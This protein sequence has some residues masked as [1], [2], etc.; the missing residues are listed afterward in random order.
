M[1]PDKTQR[2]VDLACEKGASNWLTV[3]PFKDMDFDLNSGNF[4]ML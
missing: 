1:L 4:V 3:I 2:A